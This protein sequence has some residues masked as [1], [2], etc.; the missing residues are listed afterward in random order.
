MDIPETIPHA[1]TSAL[2]MFRSMVRIR[3]AEERIADAIAAGEVKTPCH[4]GIGQEGVA[5]GM[6]AVLEKSDYAWITYRSHAQFLAKGGSMDALF[7]EIYGKAT[8]CA[9]GRGG[10]MHVVDPEVGILGTTAIV[11]GPIPLALGT[12]FASKQRGDGRVTVVFFGDGA[13]D[14]GV[15]WECIN[16]AALYTLPVVFVCENNLFASAMPLLERTPLDNLHERVATFG[17]PSERIDGNDAETVA[18]HGAKAVARAR[19]GQGPSFIECRTYRWRGHVG[20]NTDIDKGLRSKEE[21]DAWM[22][23]DPI[24]RAAR[25]ALASHQASE[26]DLEAI[27]FEARREVEAAHRFAVESP[28]PPAKEL[29]STN[30]GGAS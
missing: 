7:A 30:A 4:L 12:A 28:Y 16:F 21:L 18:R 26:K 17:L 2:A 19:G 29:L 15:F 11:A 8:G 1:R 24:T 13:M 5:A 27:R 20:P 22:A 9:G 10:S 23:K 14:E 25:S 3:L 6:C